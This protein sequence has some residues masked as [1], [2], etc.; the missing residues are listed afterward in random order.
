MFHNILKHKKT[1]IF[2]ITHQKAGSQWIKAVFSTIDNSRLVKSKIN[3]TQFFEDKIIKGGIY[4]ALYCTK[5][6]FES[7]KIPGNHKKFVVIRDL[8]DT[9]ISLYF[10]M[11]YSH[12]VL[13]EFIKKSRDELEKRD[14]ADGVLFLL[15]NG[16]IE[17]LAKI[18]NSWINSNE[19]IIKYEDLFVNE[20][21]IF[22]KIIDHCEM[23]YD[24][25]LVIDAIQ[26][27]TFQTRSKGRKAGEEDVMSHLRKGSPGDWKNYFNHKL[28]E[29][30]KDKY[31]ELIIKT[32]YES[33]SNW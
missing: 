24:R 11:R 12:P 23:K 22:M 15:E 30:F 13:N 19:M 16:Y 2:H 4:P 18:Q 32:N 9:L 6:R 14:P 17:P 33:N 7:I 21:E 1:T 8:R 29:A 26:K 10:S 31:G 20:T 3:E 28:K 5:E 27:N 25:K